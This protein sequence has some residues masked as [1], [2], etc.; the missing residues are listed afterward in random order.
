MGPRNARL[1]TLRPRLNGRSIV[2]IGLMGAGKTTVG[3]RLAKA[4]DMPFKD[5]DEEIERAANCTVSE[6]FEQFGEDYF[7]GGERRVLARLMSEAPSVIAT[8][9]GA[10]MNAETRGVIAARGVSVWL[11]ADLPVLMKR[12]SRRGHR[13]LLKTANPEETMIRLMNE[14]YPVYAQADITVDSRDGPHDSVVREI[15]R[16]LETLEV[17]PPA[18]LKDQTP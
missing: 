11:K 14:R 10:Y 2:L 16:A 8:G 18:P 12:V 4:L 15:A 1:E 3:R 5:A 7:R 6:I 17:P 13:P 9:G